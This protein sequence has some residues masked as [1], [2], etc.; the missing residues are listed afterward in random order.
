MGLLAGMGT[1]L[2][3][4]RESWVGTVCA[5]VLASDWFEQLEWKNE[6]KEIVRPITDEN[7]DW[8]C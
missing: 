4:C 7:G 3:I 2:E 6:E 5:M 8:V 1:G